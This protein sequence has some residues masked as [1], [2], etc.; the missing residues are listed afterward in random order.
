MNEWIYRNSLTEYEQRL[1]AADNERRALKLTGQPS[2]KNIVS[3][4]IAGLPQQ[5]QNR[6]RVRLQRNS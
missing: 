6:T 4:V 5:L 2:L 3:T 1:N